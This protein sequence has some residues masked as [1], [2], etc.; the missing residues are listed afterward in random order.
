MIYLSIHSSVTVSLSGL[1]QHTTMYFMVQLSFFYY[2]LKAD[3]VTHFCLAFMGLN[4]WFSTPV[5]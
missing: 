1:C 5:L 4:Q 2:F 3:E